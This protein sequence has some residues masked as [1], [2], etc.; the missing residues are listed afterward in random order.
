MCGGQRITCGSWFSPSNIGFQ[1]I[2]LLLSSLMADSLILSQV[3]SLPDAV[4]L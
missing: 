3:L 4:T 2:R 1:W